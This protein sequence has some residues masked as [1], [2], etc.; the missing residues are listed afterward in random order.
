MNFH[1]SFCMKLKV[2]GLSR[3]KLAAAGRADELAVARLDFAA[4]GNHRRPPFDLPAFEAAIVDVH[5]LGGRRDFARIVWVK[6]DEVCIAADGDC[7]FFGIEPKKL[8]GLS[9]SA[10]NKRVQIDFSG[11]DSM[12]VQQVD[13]IFH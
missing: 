6:N 11:C 5:L 8:G 4:D 10:I 9:T 3:Q 12:R 13:T 2:V 1:L 7:A